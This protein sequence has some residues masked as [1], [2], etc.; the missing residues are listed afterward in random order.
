MPYMREFFNEKLKVP[1]EFFN[2][3]QNVTVSKSAPAQEVTRSLIYLGKCWPGAP[4]RNTCAMQLNL[5]PASVVRRQE[6]EKRRPLSLWRQ[7][8]FFS[9]CSGGRLTTRGPPRW[10]G[11]AYKRCKKERH[12]ARRRNTSWYA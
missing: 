12:H 8:V 6:L 10:R 1:T 11:R 5:L 3:L 2:S 4:Q 7:R 9:F